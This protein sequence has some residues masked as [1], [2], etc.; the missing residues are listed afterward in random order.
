VTLTPACSR[1]SQ[2]SLDQT[3]ITQVQPNNTFLEAE[4]EHQKRTL[5]KR[6]TV[7]KA[8]K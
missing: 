4:A 5:S 7:L 8:L 3:V 1:A 6:D 2:E